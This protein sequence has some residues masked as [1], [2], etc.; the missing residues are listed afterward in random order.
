MS[1]RMSP[2]NPREEAERWFARLMAPDCSRQERE[3]LQRGRERSAAHAQAYVA[4]EDL[5]GR[6]DALAASDARLQV[7][8]NRARAASPEAGR[9]RAALSLSWAR[10]WALAAG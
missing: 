1:A 5:L 3:E 2:A 8:M 6:V 7:L 9:S 10:P 4:T